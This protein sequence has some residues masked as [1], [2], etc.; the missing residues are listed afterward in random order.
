MFGL[1]KRDRRNSANLDFSKNIKCQLELAKISFI[2][3][4]LST[5]RLIC[6]FQS[7]FFYGLF[8]FES[9]LSHCTLRV[10]GHQAPPLATVR[11]VM[12]RRW[13][14][15]TPVIISGEVVGGDCCHSVVTASQ[16]GAEQESSR[17][18]GYRIAFLTLGW[19]QSGLSLWVGVFFASLFID[20]RYF[21]P[22]SIIL[23]CGSFSFFAEARANKNSKG[24]PCYYYACLISVY[25]LWSY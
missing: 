7:L 14:R 20:A 12:M 16:R 11:A 24:A 1:M 13:R 6:Y 9:Q 3:S 4:A 25:F 5:F 18:H 15:D 10:C 23:K 17:C 2:C 8:W 19:F 21:F 22:S